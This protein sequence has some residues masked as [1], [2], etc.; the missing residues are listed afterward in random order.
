M[1]NINNLIKKVF[2]EEDK[3]I[4]SDLTSIVTLMKELSLAGDV[5]GREFEVKDETGK[6]IYIITQKRLDL[7]Q[8]NT[9]IKELK[10]LADIEKEEIKKSKKE[11]K[12]YKKPNPKR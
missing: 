9:L 8:I 4:P 5:L 10:L 6:V 11:A 3:I 2:K 7:N 1:S 12:P